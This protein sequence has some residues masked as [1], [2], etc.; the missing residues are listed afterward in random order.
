CLHRSYREE[1]SDVLDG[2]QGKQSVQQQPLVAFEVRNDHLAEEVGAAR[3][4]VARDDLEKLKEG[5]LQR[6]GVV[7]V[8]LSR[9]DLD[10]DG[11]PETEGLAIQHRPIA[12]DDA[13]FLEP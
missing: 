8:V 9:L 11:E 7:A 5:L 13:V 6:R 1:G 4:D 2:R 3:Y 12:G 10:E